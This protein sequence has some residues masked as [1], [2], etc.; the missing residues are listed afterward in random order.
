MRQETWS[1]ITATFL[2]H[3]GASAGPVPAAEFDE[4]FSFIPFPIGPD[5]REFV[6]RYGGGIAGGL[7]AGRC[8]AHWR[9]WRFARRC[10]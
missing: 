10:I 9:A 7:N 4:A 5:Y 3:R 6:I 2:E 8:V 1:R